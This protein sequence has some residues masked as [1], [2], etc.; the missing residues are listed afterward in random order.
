MLWEIEIRPKG[1]DG[2]L[3][4]VA[5][6]F[7]LL[8]HRNDGSAVVSATARGWLLEGPLT[9]DQADRL[10]RDLLVD[11]LAE[12]GV[13]GALNEHK[14][15]DRLATVLY[16]PGV[17]DPAAL[18]VADAARD[19]GVTV[20]SVRSFRRY[21]GPSLSL[22]AKA[23]L[24]RKVLANEAMEQVVE[25]PLTLEHLTVGAPYRFHRTVVPLRDR[26]DAGLQRLSRDGQLSLSLAEMRTI[27][28]HF[29]AAGPRPDR[30]GAGDAGPDVVGALLAQ[31]AQGQDRVP[32]RIRSSALRKSLEGDDLRRN[33]GDA[34]AARRRR[35]VRQRLRGQRRRRAL[36]RQVS[37]LLQGGD[38]Q[39][40]VGDRALRRRQHRPGRRDPRP[41]RHRPRRQARL[42]HRRLLLRPAGHAAGVAAARRPAP[43]QGDERRRC[44]SARLRQSHGHS[45]GQRRRLLRRALPRQSA[46]VLRHGRPDPGGPLPEGGPARRL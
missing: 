30:R 7:G 37:R 39:P 1:S 11:S 40:P 20:D 21:Y 2:E 45:D 28:E 14:N 27:Q 17:M 3:A 26:D 12:S 23:V 31:D 35:L 5:E 16:K 22:E 34:P 6:E 43:A 10:T 18:S 33:A 9:R 36:R 38:A 25:G 8:T 46:G 44:G 15:G 4:R 29:R 41:A 19:L 13:V 24:F 32:R 42:Q